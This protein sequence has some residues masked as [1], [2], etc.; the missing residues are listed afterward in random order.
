VAILCSRLATTSILSEIPDYQRYRLTGLSVLD[1]VHLLQRIASEAEGKLPDK[2]HQQEN[3]EYLRCV[4]V[5]LEGN[6]AALQMIVPTLKQA[7][8]DGEVLFNTILYGTCNFNDE[9]WMS[10]RFFNSVFCAIHLPSFIDPMEPFHLNHL[11]AFWTLLPEDLGYYFFLLS[12][13]AFPVSIRPEE[14]S[15]YLDEDIDTRV[16]RKRWPI[17]VARMLDAGI[18]EHATMTTKSGRKIACYHIHP[19]F[20]LIAR[21]RLTGNGL[22]SCYNPYI[23]QLLYWESSNYTTGGGRQFCERR[24]ERHDTTRGSCIQHSRNSSSLVT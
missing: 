7:D 19:I 15:G 12:D 8:Y 5:L 4:A 13:R 6:P 1:S 16:L 22:K 20:T 2:F 17:Y 9:K 21:S 11:S 23:R 18:L 3:L 10:C 24:M 14:L